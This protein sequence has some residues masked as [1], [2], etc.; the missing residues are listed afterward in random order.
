M[1]STVLNVGIPG[2]ILVFGLVAFAG[3]PTEADSDGGSTN[4][5]LGTWYNPDWEEAVKFLEDEVQI[6][7]DVQSL[8]DAIFINYGAYKVEGNSII[9]SVVPTYGGGEE[10][11]VFS[12]N[13]TSL[14]LSNPLGGY[15]EGNYTKQ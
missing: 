7:E 15:L 4:P 10:T 6:S 3:C 8:Q 14:M 9:I 5:L 13:G 12:V 2:I 11:Y 1:K